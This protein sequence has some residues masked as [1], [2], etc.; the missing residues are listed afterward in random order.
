MHIHG[1][2]NYVSRAVNGCSGLRVYL[3]RTPRATLDR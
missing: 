1:L 3:K 2:T